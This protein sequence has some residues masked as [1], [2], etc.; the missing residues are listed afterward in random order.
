MG[1]E[2]SVVGFELAWRKVAAV[3]EVFPEKTELLE[4]SFQFSVAEAESESGLGYEGGLG[5]APRAVLIN[6]PRGYRQVAS[7]P[8]LGTWGVFSGIRDNQAQR[9]L[10]L[11][12]SGWYDPGE[13]TELVDEIAWSSDHESAVEGVLVLSPG[14]PDLL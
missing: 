7:N 12:L 13:E 14:G 9:E 5:W 6:Y 4:Q 11:L 3:T 10:L 8:Y 1:A 2:Y